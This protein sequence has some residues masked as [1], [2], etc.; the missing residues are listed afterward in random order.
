MVIKYCIL[1]HLCSYNSA[2]KYTNVRC[3]WPEM[4]GNLEGW[5]IVQHYLDCKSALKCNI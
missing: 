2:A 4:Q 5:C 3:Y 1:G